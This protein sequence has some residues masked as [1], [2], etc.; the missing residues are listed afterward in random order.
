VSG[1]NDGGNEAKNRLDDREQQFCD[2]EQDSCQISVVASTYKTQLGSLDR[3]NCLRQGNTLP[4]SKATQAS[5][6]SGHGIV[7]A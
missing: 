4:E 7:F 6:A 1:S 3:G 2:I 5:S